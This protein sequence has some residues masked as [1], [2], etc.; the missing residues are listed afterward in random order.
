MLAIYQRVVAGIGSGKIR[1][2]R[3]AGLN[4]VVLVGAAD[5]SSHSGY[6]RWLQFRARRRRGLD[7]HSGAIGGFRHSRGIMDVDRSVIGSL[8]CAGQGQ[9]TKINLVLELLV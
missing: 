6:A 5:Q 4:D 9:I 3:K 7:V 2:A 8:R 1:V